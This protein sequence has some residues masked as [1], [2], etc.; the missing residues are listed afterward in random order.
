[1]EKTIFEITPE[2]YLADSRGIDP[3]TK[4]EITFCLFGITPMPRIL[5]SNTEMFLFGDIF[6]RNF[7]SAYDMDSSTVMLGTDVSAA[8]MA[9][10]RPVDPSMMVPFSLLLVATFIMTV[11]FICCCIKRSKKKMV[12]YVGN[13]G[14]S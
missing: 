7:Y 9:S 3:R 6:L 11:I 4:K 10:M 1:M 5:G 8:H 12:K 13:R 2:G 14:V